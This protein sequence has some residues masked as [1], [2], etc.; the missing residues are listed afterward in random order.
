MDASHQAQKEA[1]PRT[2]RQR[3]IT[4][5]VECRVRCSADACSACEERMG[6]VLIVKDWMQL[7]DV[8][9]SFFFR[10][11]FSPTSAH[12]ITVVPWPLLY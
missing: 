8:F 7:S 10:G 5:L 11:S 3:A 2:A 6:R 1:V 9:V 12:C 4:P